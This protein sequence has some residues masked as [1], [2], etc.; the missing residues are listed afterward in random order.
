M[1]AFSA[2]WQRAV[3]RGAALWADEKK[4]INLLVGAGLAGLLLLAFS[5]WIPQQDP[6]ALSRSPSRG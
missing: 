1:K 2:L 5:E 4:R 3:Q 6:G